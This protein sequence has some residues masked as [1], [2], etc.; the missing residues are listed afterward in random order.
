MKPTALILN[1]F[2]LSSCCDKTEF[3]QGTW[4]HTLARVFDACRTCQLLKTEILKTTSLISIVFLLVSCSNRTEFYLGKWELNEENGISTLSLSENG[5]LNWDIS[6]VRVFENM[7]YEAV[8]TS[9]QNVDITAGQGGDCI[10]LTLQRLTKNQ[11]MGWNY[12]C[13]IDENMIDEVFIA[14][15]MG[16]LSNRYKNQ[17]K[18]RLYCQ[19]DI[20]AYSILSI[21]I[22][23]ETHPVKL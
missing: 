17:K 1:L 16:I 15:K 7:T 9:R 3:Y 4:D 14:R 20:L 21:R 12:K 8:E 13:Y 10:K 22:Q 11:F 5:K 19:M 6:G 23:R 18:K 2:L